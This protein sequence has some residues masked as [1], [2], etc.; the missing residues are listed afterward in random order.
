MQH[1]LITF[2]QLVAAGIATSTIVDWTASGRLV[3]VQPRV[4]RVS[5]APIT[6]EQQVLAA[7]LAAGPGAAASHRTAAALWGLLTG[8]V[9]EIV[10]PRGRT[11]D[12]RG[13]VVHQT[14]D[15]IVVSTRRGI[16]VTTPMRTL[17]DLGAV[18]P[19]SVVEV[20]L[21]AAEVARLLTVA[22]VEWELA[23]VARPGRRGTGAIRQ[24]LDRR[25]L[26]DEPPDGMLEPRF[27]RLCKHAGLPTPVFQHPVGRYR[28]D[29]AY[30]DLLL[31][32]EVDGY[33]PHASRKAFQSDRERQN[34]LVVRG[35]TVLRF[36]WADVV[37]RP[38]H[39]AKV[40]ADAI[41]RAHFRHRTRARPN[42]RRV[43]LATGC[44]RRTTSFQV[45]RRTVHPWPTRKFCRSRSR[46]N[47]RRVDRGL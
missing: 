37:K 43:G 8:R 32:I 29:F 40:V 34:T 47:R 38:E 2:A 7:V 28:I 11:P 5:G 44:G 16:P 19:A 41:G 18:V 35:W 9:I 31:A 17:V 23:A 20:A 25:A 30:P 14:R 6:W 46:W 15:P 22:G 39:V 12:L 3:Q 27:A 33:G 36:T 26:L 21:D 45:N 4:Y 10:V 13:V 24:V 1:G 42:S